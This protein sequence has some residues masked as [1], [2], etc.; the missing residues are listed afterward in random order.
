MEF[1]KCY[2]TFSNSRL[3]YYI[4]GFLYESLQYYCLTISIIHFTLFWGFVYSTENSIIEMISTNVGILVSTS[5]VLNFKEEIN[6]LVSIFPSIFM[7]VYVI[8]IWLLHYYLNVEW[9]V[10]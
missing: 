10:K 7:F 1:I 4:G 5:Y 2:C 8:M 6:K 9:P 3:L